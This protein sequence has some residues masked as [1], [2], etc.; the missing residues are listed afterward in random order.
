M[1]QAPARTRFATW[2]RRQTPARQIEILLRKEGYTARV[3]ERRAR[4]GILTD[5]PPSLV[6][7][8]RRDVLN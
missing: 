5:A 7:D 2:L 3:I 6:A 4:F 1:E 8:V